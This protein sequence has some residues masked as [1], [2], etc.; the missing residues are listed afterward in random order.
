MAITTLLEKSGAA[1]GSGKAAWQLWGGLT[2]KTCVIKEHYGIHT[3]S[4]TKTHFVSYRGTADNECF[5][6]RAC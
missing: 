1:S 2:M 5:D 6:I 4:V 3:V